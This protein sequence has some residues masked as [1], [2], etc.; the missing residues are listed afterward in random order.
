MDYKYK[1]EKWLV[2]NYVKNKIKIEDIAKECNVSTDTIYR[3]LDKYKIPRRTNKSIEVV[4][5]NCNKTF[6]KL[7]CEINKGNGNHYCSQ[8]CCKEYR[9]NNIEFN[10][11]YKDEN[12]KKCSYCGKNIRV[13]KS[14]QN[15]NNNNFCSRECFGKW[16][17]ENLIGKMASNYKNAL[18]Y[19]ICSICNKEFTTYIETQIC[20]S[21]E[22]GNK[23]KKNTK[24]LICANCNNEFERTVSEIYW[25]NKR[26]NENVFC[27]AKCKREYHIGENHPSYIENRTKLKDQ[28]KSIRW[29]TEM[30][31]WRKEIYARDNY[32]CQMCGNKSGINNVV[33]LNAHHIER[34][35]DNKDMRFNIENGITLCET[36]HKLT[37]GKEKYFEQYFKNI[38]ENKQQII[39]MVN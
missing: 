2:E 24:I 8:K 14:K 31:V 39:I 3:W 28:N 36:C 10:P 5:L 16:E 25:G 1:D 23:H 29:S 37:Y 6:K 35:I 30:K 9:K 7:Q 34:F 32:S 12:S 21:L 17:S 20:C 4:C 18:L 22:C 26:G 19:K 11:N 13:D 33:V 38:L 15:R 27:S